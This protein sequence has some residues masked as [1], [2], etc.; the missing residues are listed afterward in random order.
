MSSLES[1]YN[2]ALQALMQ[3]RDAFEEMEGTPANPHSK[4]ALEMGQTLRQWKEAF[5]IDRLEAA[6]KAHQEQIGEVTYESA[7]G[8]E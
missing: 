8:T 6:A 3:L 4:K 7:G 5:G 2:A 1:N